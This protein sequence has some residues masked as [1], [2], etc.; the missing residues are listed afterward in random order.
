M[1]TLRGDNICNAVDEWNMSV[2]L[3]L[4]ELCLHGRCLKGQ[5]QIPP[6][7]Q[8]MTIWGK[9][10]LTC[11][12]WRKHVGYCKSKCQHPCVGYYDRKP[13]VLHESGG[14]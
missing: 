1:E 2:P 10:C 6:R 7:L 5:G 13:G 12:A 8:N 11:H 9:L 4:S 14:Y 3:K